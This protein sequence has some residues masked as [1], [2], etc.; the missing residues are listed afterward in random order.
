[1]A[2][3]YA[4]IKPENIRWARERA[5]LDIAVLAKKLNIADEKLLGWES[6]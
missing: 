1:M 6:G 3:E 2:T 4:Q 5:Q